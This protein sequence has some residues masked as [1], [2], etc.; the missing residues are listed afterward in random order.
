MGG[1]CDRG[2]VV[3]HPTRQS[4]TVVDEVELASE[5]GRIG[6]AGLL[7]EIREQ[8]SDP[9]PEL[10]SGLLNETARWCL[11]GRGDECAAIEVGLLVLLCLS[12]EDGQ[13]LLA[14]IVDLLDRFGQPAGRAVVS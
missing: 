10:V 3:V 4:R 5:A 14:W 8:G 12:I 9:R 6:S 1:R 13:D 7:G 2:I 11:R